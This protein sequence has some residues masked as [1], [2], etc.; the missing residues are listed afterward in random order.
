MKL[1]NFETD[2]RYSLENNY[3]RRINRYYYKVFPELDK[4]GVVESIELQRK[5]IDKVLQMKSGKK[6]LVDEKKRRKDYGDILLEEYS[7]WETRRPGWLGRGHYTDYIVYV[8]VETGK[9][10]LLPFLI[11]QKAWRDNYAGWKRNY[12]TIQARNQTYTTTSLCIPIDILF[13]ALEKAMRLEGYLRTL[14][15][16]GNAR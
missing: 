15:G 6:I 12:R 14:K 13:R 2:L 9:V 7:N 1:N 11:L 10:Y 3:D 5:G 16:E 8:I 4:I